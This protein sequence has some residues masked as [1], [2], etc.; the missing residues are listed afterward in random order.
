LNDCPHKLA[1]LLKKAW[2]ASRSNIPG[3]GSV[4]SSAGWVL[5]PQ[6]IIANSNA[7]NEN[8]KKI[9]LVIVMVFDE[10]FHLSGEY[11]NSEDSFRK[12]Q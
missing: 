2:W 3:A 10:K 6:L 9:F 8:I 7:G 4:K 11:S 12:I 5:G 1:R